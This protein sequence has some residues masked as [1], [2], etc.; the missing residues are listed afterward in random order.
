M[1]QPTEPTQPEPSARVEPPKVT[2]RREDDLTHDVMR[3]VLEVPREAA[4]RAFSV[5]SIERAVRKTIA[6]FGITCGVGVEV[7]NLLNDAER[8]RDQEATHAR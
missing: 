1:T 7:E 2:L 5:D 8:T 3:V 6:T 4:L